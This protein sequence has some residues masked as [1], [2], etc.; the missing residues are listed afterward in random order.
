MTEVH[1]SLTAWGLGLAA[2]AYALL[3][4]HLLRQGYFKTLVNRA[5]LA[6]IV[7]SVLTAL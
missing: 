4:M 1:N 2:V 7:A 6:I 5:G 3:A